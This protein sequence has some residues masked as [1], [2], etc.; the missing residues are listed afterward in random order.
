MLS[1]LGVLSD[2]LRI[3]LRESDV[4]IAFNIQPNLVLTLLHLQVIQGREADSN[5]GVDLLQS[6]SQRLTLGLMIRLEARHRRWHI[7]LES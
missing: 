2:G 5:R 7:S 1:G 4:E 3:S 6:F